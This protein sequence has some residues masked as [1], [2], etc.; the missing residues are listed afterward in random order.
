[1][2]RHTWEVK[3]NI[4]HQ[5]FVMSLNSHGWKFMK[6]SSLS[7][8]WQTDRHRS[9]QTAVCVPCF[10]PANM[11]PLK[12][13][14]SHAWRK[15]WLSSTLTAWP[16]SM[17]QHHNVQ[18]CLGI[19]TNVEAKWPASVHDPRLYLF[20]FSVPANHKVGYSLMMWNCISLYS[21]ICL[22]KRNIFPCG[23]LMMAQ[24]KN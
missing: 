10:P 19:I 6:S 13:A 18:F 1:M 22:Y 9:I 5:P 21:S 8:A 12:E 24:A 15:S 16:G 7:P 20:L 2:G 4:I 23:S 14:S 11:P 17:G 3:W